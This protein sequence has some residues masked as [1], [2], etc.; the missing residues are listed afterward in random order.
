[1]FYG[2]AVERNRDPDGTPHNDILV[3]FEFPKSKPQL[4]VRRTLV[5]SPYDFRLGISYNAELNQRA[6]VWLRIDTASESE[7]KGKAYEDF[8]KPTRYVRQHR[9]AFIPSPR[10]CS[11]L[12]ACMPDRCI[13]LPFDSPLLSCHTQSSCHVRRSLSNE[14]ATLA[15]LSRMMTV[16]L[17]D[18]LQSYDD[19]K[20]DLLNEKPYS[21]E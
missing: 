14:V 9:I 4:K 17:A 6:R 5:K 10:R 18:Y 12:P 19:D 3:R 20:K 16:R 13:C 11:H 8:E 1:M 7:L 2:F 15:Q 21:N